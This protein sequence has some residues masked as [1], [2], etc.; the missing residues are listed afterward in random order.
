M[1]TLLPPSTPPRAVAG[2]APAVD[3]ASEQVHTGVDGLAG[4][5]AADPIA[6]LEAAG[7]AIWHDGGLVGAYA[8]DFAFD[9]GGLA[10]L[11]AA[12]GADGGGEIG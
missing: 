8:D 12:D 9:A 7:V 11:D 6:S 5:S 10:G 4:A 1:G 3:D 2:T